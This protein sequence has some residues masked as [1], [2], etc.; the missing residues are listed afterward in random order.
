MKSKLTLLM[1]RDYAE[2]VQHSA[3]LRPAILRREKSQPPRII[4]NLE[5]RK[6]ADSSI[7]IDQ[8]SMLLVQEILG[9]VPRNSIS[10]AT[11]YIAEDLAENSIG[12]QIL[13]KDMSWLSSLHI[14][15][16]YEVFDAGSRIV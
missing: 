9:K 7:I 3:S 4:L 13:E 1:R 8:N 6:S 2:L 11:L 16:S 12:V 10:K 5:I 15:F 14:D